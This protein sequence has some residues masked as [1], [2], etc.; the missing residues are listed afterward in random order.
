[1]TSAAATPLPI[2]RPSS[3]HA[4]TAAPSTPT[5]DADDAALAARIAAGDLPAFERLLRRFNRPLYRVARAIVKDD[6]DAED[7]LQEAMLRA[8]RAMGSFRGEARLSTW[9]VRIVANEALARLRTRTRRGEILPLQPDA[10]DDLDADTTLPT[11]PDAMVSASAD[12]E[13]VAVRAELRRLLERR[14]D[15]L[16][17]AFRTVFVLR[18]LH[19]LSVEETAACLD[20]PAATVRTRFF[21]ARSL[22]REALACDI[23]RAYDGA[24]DF[25]GADCDRITARVLARIADAG[26]STG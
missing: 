24:Y 9:L 19:D 21:R 4:S 25:G 1:M 10:I 14:I 15:A 8:Y 13:K 7:V 11:E 26:P 17:D 12:P 5:S 23:D 16:P 6:V 20:L 22:L 2:D 3:G 18:A